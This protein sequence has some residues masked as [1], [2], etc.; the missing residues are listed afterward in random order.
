MTAA[1]ATRLVPNAP[2]D[3]RI[4]RLLSL[5]R[6][7]LIATLLAI[8]EGG[9]GGFFFLHVWPKLFH[10]ACLAYAVTAL[11]ML[12]PMLY[13]K[14]GL[15]AQAHLH[16]AIDA[17]AIT[18]LVY[19]SGGVP[20]GLG[21]LLVTPALACAIPV[22]SR[23]AVVHAAAATLM[24]FGEEILRQSAIGFS[25]TEFTAAGL[26][27]LMFF[28]TS[29]G[30]NIVASR[31]R[32]SEALAARVGSD[33]ASMSR[34][35]DSIIENMQTGVMVLDAQRR[36]QTINNAAQNLLKLK[37]ATDLPLS[38]LVPALDEGAQNWL[39]GGDGTQTL[40][41]GDSDLSVRYTR[42]G[43]GEEAPILILMEDATLLREQAQQMKLAALGRLSA[44]IA[45]E[46]RNPL[47]AISHAGQLLAESGDI[48]GDNQRLLGM[49]QRHSQRIDKIIRDVL[50]ISRRETATRTVLPLKTWLIRAAGLYQEA[51]AERPRP[52][53]LLDISPQ[54]SV[55]F[56][57]NHLQQVVFNLWDN[58][59][60][61]GHG[62]NPMVM[63]E[64]GHNDNGSVWL[65]IR[66][67]GPGIADE[68]HDRIFEPFFTT[69]TQGTGLGLYLSR[70]LCE[71][72]HARLYYLPQSTG[73]CFRIVFPLD[74]R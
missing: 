70:E 10:Y 71:Y 22:S 39:H 45:H 72:N 13:R 1:A 73:A 68:L 60:G 2:E 11:L 14:P 61:H 63:L 56:D 18:L 3:W 20:N 8:Y 30:A 31:A 57:P 37:Q 48:S 65:D 51:Y 58:S 55:S 74:K 38:T 62:N 54:L 40:H 66:D 46:I 47:S 64:A 27:G 23:M 16:F 15:G 7:V 21:I 4:L 43:W 17:C 35:N 29:T 59:F 32:R 67:N 5:Y 44:S 19:A 9:F 49:I 41:L 33:L 53:E 25:A 50:D 28:V 69:A 34:L 6:L 52:I 36:I 26:L 42:L 12:L 24:M